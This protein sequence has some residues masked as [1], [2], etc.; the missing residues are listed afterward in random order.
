VRR[1]VDGGDG[2][3]KLR[4]PRIYGIAASGYDGTPARNRM[5]PHERKLTHRMRVPGT[6]APCEDEYEH[7]QVLAWVAARRTDVTQRLQWRSEIRG[8]MDELAC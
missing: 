3:E 1:A 4:P 2:L 7:A 5:A 8:L 6:A